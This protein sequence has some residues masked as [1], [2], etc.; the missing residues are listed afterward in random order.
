M[1]EP[2][3]PRLLV[4][5]AGTGTEIGKTWVTFEAASMLRRELSLDVAA[6]KPAQSFDPD[7]DSTDADLLASA[8]R[9]RPYDVCPE[10]RWYPTPMAPPMAADALGLD[11]IELTALAT[12]VSTSWPGRAPDIGFVEL[13]G[14]VRSP[15]AHDG[16]GVDLISAL[17]PDIVLLVAD[18]GLG[19][20]NSVRLSRAAISTADAPRTIVALNRYDDSVA[21]HRDNRRWLITHD[22][23]E[24]VVSIG[25]LV[26][27][28]HDALPRWCA[29]CGKRATECD[30]D[31]LP[32]LDPPRHC[33][34]CGRKV[35]VTIIPT[36]TTTRCKTHGII[37]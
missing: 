24:V 27:V 12:E 29:G 36:G 30:G 10:H 31:C 9:S 37:E 18:A 4:V 32:P 35:V 28:L 25:E 13:A 22:G 19:T 23:V 34:V 20:I 16:D 5:V 14:G 11:P 26:G 6:R 15:M 21:L 8:T 17:N 33:P 1:R 3:R 2:T 7:D